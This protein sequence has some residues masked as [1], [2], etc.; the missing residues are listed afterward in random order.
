MHILDD[1]DRPNHQR[2]TPAGEVALK[3]WM[4]AAANKTIKNRELRDKF[5]IVL[6]NKISCAP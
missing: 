6:G 2:P 1:D 4:R 3:D 5:T